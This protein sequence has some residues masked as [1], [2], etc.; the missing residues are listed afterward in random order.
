MTVHIGRS[1]LLAAYT[2]VS[3]TLGKEPL[4]SLHEA[5]MRVFRANCHPQLTLD[6]ARIVLEM[7]GKPS[8]NQWRL[9]AAAAKMIRASSP[10]AN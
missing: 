3:E 10:S 6:V 9:M 7:S 2:A 8:E 1:E 4:E 5:A